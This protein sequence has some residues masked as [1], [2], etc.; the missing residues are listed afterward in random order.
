MTAA[1]DVDVSAPERDWIVTE[2][3]TFSLTIERLKDDG[4]AWDIT[5]WTFWLTVK[6][7]TTNTDANAVVGPIKNTTHT[8]PANGK[9][10]FELSASDTDN[11]TGRYHYDVQQKRP[12]GS[13]KTV[14]YGTMYF[15]ADVTEATS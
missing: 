9:T 6:E 15:E 12:N 7:S 1:A 5:G 3:D 13:I 4:T 8:A 2:G 14:L 10:S 11:L